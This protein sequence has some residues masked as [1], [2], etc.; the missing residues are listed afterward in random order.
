MGNAIS[1]LMD[2]FG[3]RLIAIR[4]GSPRTRKRMKR[5]KHRKDIET[6]KVIRG[7]D[8]DSDELFER[9]EQGVMVVQL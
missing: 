2:A 4:K 7:D 9:D 5:W 8:Y 3:K 1:K 6:Y